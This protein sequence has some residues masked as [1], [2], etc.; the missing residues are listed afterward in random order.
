[1]AIATLHRVAK[2][3]ANLFF[4]PVDDN[5]SCNDNDDIGDEQVPQTTS[6]QAE[7]SSD[8]TFIPHVD[9]IEE[10]KSPLEY[11]RQFW[12]DEIIDLAPR[13]WAPQSTL[14]TTKPSNSLACT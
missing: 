9:N 4:L 12:T 11:F 2:F 7:K 14:P 1:M 5:G 13:G 3:S 8:E 6:K 10:T